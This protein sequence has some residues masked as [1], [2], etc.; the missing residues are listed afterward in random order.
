MSD[1]G[2]DP[3]VLVVLEALKD[4]KSDAWTW[5]YSLGRFTDLKTWVQLDQ[6]EVWSFAEGTRGPHMLAGPGDIHRFSNEGY[7]KLE[8]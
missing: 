6:E 1:S 7:L 2:T 4:R 3:E 8:E 5:H